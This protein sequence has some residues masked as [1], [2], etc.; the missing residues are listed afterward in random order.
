MVSKLTLSHLIV[1]FDIIIEVCRTLVMLKTQKISSMIHISGNISGTN[2]QCSKILNTL[3]CI[4][5]CKGR[6]LMSCRVFKLATVV[7]VM[8]LILM[9]FP[10]PPTENV[11][12][13]PDPSIQ[14][15]GTI[16]VN[17]SGGGDYLTIQDGINAAGEGDIIHVEAGIYY[18]N[19]VVNKTISLVGA[20]SESTTI[21]GGGE[22]DVLY[23]NVNWVNVSDL[24]IT[25]SGSD[26]DDAGVELDRV[27]NCRIEN[28]T[29]S[30]NNYGIFLDFSSSNMIA[31]NT[32]NPD[33]DYGILLNQAEGNAI[34]NNTSS[35]NGCGVMLSS[36]SNNNFLFN[37]TITGNFH[38]G[39]DIKSDGGVNNTI[40]NNIISRNDEDPSGNYPTLWI[41]TD[42][43]KIF[44][45]TITDNGG[46]GI[47][48]K[49]ASNNS[50]E[51]NTCSNNWDGIKLS[52]DSSNNLLF[53]NVVERNL[54]NGIFLYKN[55]GSNN[56]IKFNTIKEN[57]N[58]QTGVYSGIN[59]Q[60]NFSDI[61]NN[62]IID[63]NGSAI[64][65]NSG[66]NNTI[67]NNTCNSNNGDGIYILSSE[68]NT[69]KT[70][71]CNFNNVFGIYLELN[72]DYNMIVNNVCTSNKW[73]GIEVRTSYNILTNNTCNSNIKAGMKLYLGNSNKARN[74]TCSSNNRSG[75]ELLISD[76]NDIT[77]NS[78]P[79]NNESGV[80]I[81]SSDCNNIINNTCNLNKENGIHLLYSDDNEM[82]N[83]TCNM[84]NVS[85]FNFETDCNSNTVSE[86]VCSLNRRNGISIPGGRGQDN[87][88]IIKNAFRS[89]SNHGISLGEGTDSN[90][91]HLNSLI[92]NNLG[93]AQASDNGTDNK[94]NTT[95]E[96]NY[97]SDWRTPDSDSDGIVDHPYNIDGNANS[98]DSFPL[99]KPT[100]DSYPIANAGLDITI[101]L[102]STIVFNGSGSWGFQN[103]VN[104]TWS[105]IYEDTEME[106]YG[107]SP[108]FI[109]HTLGTYP[110]T[111]NV[112]DSRGR[113]DTDTML[114]HVIDITPPVARAG[115]D[116][117]VDQH[118]TVF[119]NGSA[120]YDNIDI[121]EHIWEFVYDG[122]P[123]NL[124]GE[125][126]TFTFHASGIY[127]ITLKV[128][129][130][131]GNRGTDILNVTVIDITP[132]KAD[133]GPDV[134]LDQNDVLTLDGTKSS[135]NVGIVNYTWTFEYDNS[136]QCLFGPRPRF[137]FNVVGNYN[138]TL[139]IADA[140][141]LWD[142]DTVR[143]LV[144]FFDSEKPLADA[145][146]D[147][148]INSTEIAFFNGGGSFD[149]VGIENYTWLFFY[150]GRLIKLY[151]PE[152]SFIF[153]VSGKYTITLKVTDDQGNLA[154]DVLNITVYPAVD[155]DV[156]KD[157]EE[158][159]SSSNVCIWIIIVLFLATLFGV[160]VYFCRKK[161]KEEQLGK[162]EVRRV[163]KTEHKAKN[164]R[165]DSENTSRK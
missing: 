143:V 57:D 123:E 54:H 130:S 58:D 6:F 132:P 118:D 85:G 155:P 45:N 147:I 79:Y 91:I 70:N 100:S 161:E 81:L 46:H 127:P 162:N 146:D 136:E 152:S 165:V 87:N 92:D 22:G 37:N 1:P 55:A 49:Y 44:N 157:D 113:S 72:S 148:I 151:G 62:T 14:T 105:F 75:I 78:C 27:D 25:N 90:V 99:T 56:I 119:F 2:G 30:N 71:I 52:T 36:H 89:N 23:I 163:E 108:S 39:I 60:S 51:N 121:V 59:I 5:E 140:V 128:I 150:D 111:L 149:N 122:Y 21:D 145:G 74:N 135:D 107:I 9:V 61:K 103:I 64:F 114:V 11:I 124:S 109:F 12:A 10:F 86:N 138:V 73:S 153:E 88:I 106:L 16:V 82:I 159:G 116:I 33:N 24:K 83:N 84:N 133:A 102:H 139:R 137:T 67:E 93:G 34:I 110:V 98:K 3:L 65:V 94:W 66:S 115:P 129:D 63:N 126:A 40:K 156:D 41:G 154:L 47:Y 131:E 95:R 8:G 20:S 104:Y 76:T 144:I 141:N 15:R 18:E 97:W 101:G 32:I 28:N 77:N 160:M 112:T 48:L 17:A 96:G 26:Q 7:I 125:T 19:V 38:N 142:E 69:V 43:N 158:N 68:N 53:Q 120:S 31:N 117:I 42:R 164:G 13:F 134:T 4:F 80:S 35:N 50:I 29:C